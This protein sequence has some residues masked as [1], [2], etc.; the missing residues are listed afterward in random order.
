MERTLAPSRADDLICHLSQKTKQELIE[1]FFR[2]LS[3]KRYRYCDVCAETLQRLIQVFVFGYLTSSLA[4]VAFDAQPHIHF[5]FTLDVELSDVA[6]P[7]DAVKFL[8]A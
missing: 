1:K 4:V 3:E 8:N 7:I 6:F 2:G 5:Y